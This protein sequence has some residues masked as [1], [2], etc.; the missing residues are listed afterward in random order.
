VGIA[1]RPKFCTTG[2][3]GG[4]AF[5]WRRGVLKPLGTTAGLNNSEGVH[6]NSIGQVVGYSFTCDFSAF[7]A[8]LWEDNHIVSL[9]S[10]TLPDNSFHLWSAVFIDDRGQIAALGIEPNRN[11]HAVLLIPCDENHPHDERCDYSVIDKTNIT[12]Q[13]PTILLQPLLSGRSAPTQRFSVFRTTR[14]GS[15]LQGR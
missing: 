5:L 13:N 9:N 11:Q 1:Q 2:P 8:F 7:D 15:T 3:G 10:L 6:I 4:E 12:A 14:N